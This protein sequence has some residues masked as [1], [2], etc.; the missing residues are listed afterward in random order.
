MSTKTGSSNQRDTVFPHSCDAQGCLI[1][2]HK[3]LTMGECIGWSSKVKT[4][5]D[6]WIDRGHFNTLGSA[7]YQD[8]SDAYPTIANLNN[9]TL[10]EH[11]EPL[12]RK[13][14]DFYKADYEQPNGVAFPGFHIFRED[15]NGKQGHAHID[16]PFIHI[17]WG[18]EIRNPFSFTLLIEQ[19][20]VGASMDYWDQVVT[21]EHLKKV[22]LEDI[23]PEHKHF[24]YSL[25]ILYT[26]NGL[27]PHRIANTGDMQTGEYRITLQ[28]HGVTLENGKRV[29]Y[30]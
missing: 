11:F 10:H 1:A 22:L 18:Q 17:N 13:V 2:S 19:P 8:P 12:L 24:R 26:H 6:K 14:Y 3:F 25:G 27:F 4:L 28:G 9:P 21:E 15:A 30:F 16:E 20:K 5:Q 23:Y 29:L 7:T